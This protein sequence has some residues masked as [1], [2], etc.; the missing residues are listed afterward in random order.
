MRFRCQRPGNRIG[1]WLTD[2][3]RSHEQLVPSVQPESY[4]PS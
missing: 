2:Q 3:G 4:Q 1:D